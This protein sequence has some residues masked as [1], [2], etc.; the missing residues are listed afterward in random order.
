MENVSRRRFLQQASLG[1]AAVG[2]IAATAGR[3][4]L[5][6]AAAAAPAALPGAAHVD[7]P[8]IIHLADVTTGEMQVFAGTR[9]VTMR[10]R[11]LAARVAAALA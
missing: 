11:E 10:D 7:G 5:H 8:V 3:S 2:A 6:P 9:E 1:V 4:T